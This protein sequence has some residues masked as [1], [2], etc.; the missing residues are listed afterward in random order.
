METRTLKVD[1]RTARS[2]ELLQAAMKELIRRKAYDRIT[3]EDICHEAKVGRSTFYAHY[4]SKDDLKR[5]GLENLRGV[6]LER[7]T[8]SSRDSEGHGG[9]SFSLALFDH[10][11]G[12]VDIYRALGKGR[13]RS[14]AMEHLQHI[15]SDL[16]RRE[17][18]AWGKGLGKAEEN[19]I[20]PEFAE[21][22]L[23][24]AFMSVLTW[25][26]EGGAKEEPVDIDAMFRRM[27]AGISLRHDG[28]TSIR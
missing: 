19:A 18:A 24:G 1:R 21:R 8:L 28:A 3:I 20:P 9:L 5:K 12:H 25:W 17:L 13:G 15:L 27:V 7:Q 23:V 26:L 6:L 2:R 22:Y 11:R 4:S 16:I 10:A 14:V